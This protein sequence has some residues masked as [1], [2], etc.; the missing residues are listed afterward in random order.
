MR[1]CLKFRFMPI[2]SRQPV[3]MGIFSTIAPPRRP[4]I[5]ILG[6]LVAHGALVALVPVLVNQLAS[7]YSDDEIDWAA[8][9]VEPMRLRVPDIIY[10]EA[11]RDL[12]AN[13]ESRAQ[14]KSVN[15]RGLGQSVASPA[16]GLGRSLAPIPTGLELPSIKGPESHSAA[17]LQPEV[18]PNPQ[19]RP[20]PVPRL[21]FWARQ[22][23]PTPQKDEVR[24]PGR[25][26]GSALP[27]VLSA[28]PVLAV[29]NKESALADKNV[30]TTPPVPVASLPIAPSSTAP[31]RDSSGEARNGVYDRAAGEYTNII[32]L[33][34]DAV[35]PSQIVSVPPGSTG[36]NS[37]AGG[38]VEGRSGGNVEHGNNT[39]S[40]SESRR[41]V[42]AGLPAQPGSLR[43]GAA[44]SQQGQTTEKAS[45]ASGVA[46]NGVNRRL[47][48]NTPVSKGSEAFTRIMH[49][50]NGAFDVVV[51]Q[52]TVGGDL[53]GI[54]TRLSG[55]PVYTVY[56]RVGDIKEWVLAF[57]LPVAKTTQNSRYEVYIDDATPLSPPY[58]IKTTIPQSII[59]QPRSTALVFRGVLTAEGAL[60][61]MEASEPGATSARIA[62]VLAEWQFRPAR[63]SNSPTEIQIA[64]II[65]A[66]DDQNKADA[67]ARG[68]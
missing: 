8:Y 43:A 50:P 68:I 54:P 53:P 36:A 32:A 22:Q 64:L 7:F 59:G 39:D 37:Q 52:S 1:I 63:K 27:P 2:P 16:A 13:A 56:L 9:R 29:S 11:P 51:T 3:V 40:Q 60:R 5:A 48:P 24:L 26:E 28:P 18:L 30:A 23:A 61:N 12:S 44:G 58:P 10:Y 25:A 38:Q 66:T 46:V 35:R 21:A 19:W 14:Q 45:T 47:A 15:R 41:E 20:T 31:L 67:P 33:S 49:P 62:A 6:S 55:S 4:W 42:T 34:A 65:P 57:C 17:V